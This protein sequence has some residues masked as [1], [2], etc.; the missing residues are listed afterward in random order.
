MSL[1]AFHIVFVVISIMMCLVVGV[2]GLF[3]AAS[4]GH[5]AMMQWLGYAG[6]AGAVL[7]GVYGA[8]FLRKLK[9]FSY[10]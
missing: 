3:M 5:G 10:V 7:L 2:W 4:A 8:W 6:F 1:K 9:R